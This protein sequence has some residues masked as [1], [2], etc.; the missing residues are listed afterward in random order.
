MRRMQEQRYNVYCEDLEDL[1][2]GITSLATVLQA[3]D[4]ASYKKARKN[5][6]NAAKL[7]DYARN[8]LILDEVID[9]DESWNYL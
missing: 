3:E 2:D 9:G 4:P 7:L 1:R 6:T 5:L 8:L